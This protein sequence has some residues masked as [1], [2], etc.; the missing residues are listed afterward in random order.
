M[1][2]R[3]FSGGFE[4]HYKRTRKEK[5]LAEMDQVIPKEQ[6]TKEFAPHY[7]DPQG[8]GRQPKYLERMLRIYFLQHWDNFPDPAMEEALYD[9][10][11]MCESARL[12]VGEEHAPDESTILQFSHLMERHEFGAELLRL[13]NACLAE[14]GNGLMAHRNRVA[15]ELP[16]CQDVDIRLGFLPAG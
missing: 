12:D 8:S 14:Q 16:G 7:P 10:R 13:V 4:K 2:Q 6:L 15:R 9:S 5:F 11:G 3:S 1:H